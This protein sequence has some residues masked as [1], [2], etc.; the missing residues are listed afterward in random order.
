MKKRTLLFG[1]L[2]IELTAFFFIPGDVTAY[3][4]PEPPRFFEPANERDEILRAVTDRDLRA[5]HVIWILLDGVRRKEAYGSRLNPF[6]RLQK[7]IDAK[8][9]WT[10]GDPRRN[11]EMR[12]SNDYAKSL[13]GYQAMFSGRV[14]HGQCSGN[15]V[16]DCPHQTDPTIHDALA[17]SG[18]SVVSVA[19]WNG[20]DRAVS[21]ESSA[22]FLHYSAFGRAPALPSKVDAD[23][24]EKL[25][26][27]SRADLPPWKDCMR[28]VY[29]YGIARL[30]WYSRH[31]RLET[32]HWVDADEWGHLDDFSRYI[33]TLETYDLW[34]DGLIAAADELERAGKWG[35]TVFV[36]T[37]DH[38][39]GEGRSVI[40]DKFEE[41]GIWQPSS[42]YHWAWIRVPESLRARYQPAPRPRMQ[43]ADLRPTVERLLN[44]A[45]PAG[46]EGRSLIERQ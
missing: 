23:A 17:K 21:A 3:R 37:T 36:V 7:R 35:P 25:A 31:P 40:W 2:A 13:P 8:E 26:A 15:S 5:P 18:N 46:I 33:E 42:Y 22:P 39:R 28:D 44:E 24:F 32:I 19:A 16:S 11:E 27:E 20:L 1:F 4:V 34:I 6:P 45:S 29:A 12:V 43:Q 9:F 41:H 30:L 38:G 10:F 14:G